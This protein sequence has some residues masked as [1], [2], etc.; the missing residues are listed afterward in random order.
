[1]NQITRIP[2]RLDRQMFSLLDQLFERPGSG[3]GCATPNGNGLIKDLAEA[4]LPLDLS[5]SGDEYLVRASLPGFP[6]ESVTINVEEGVLTIRAEHREQK[7]ESN[8]R[9]IHT[10]RRFTS[11][12]R[13]VELPSKIDASGAK[14][15]LK[16]G[17]LTV[18]LPK[19]ATAFAKTIAI[20]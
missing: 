18:R 1:M 12:S 9:F 11:L 7:D 8:E 17:V 6:K 3:F 5:E 16:D 20:Q 13:R 14:A 15:E 10:E 4:P 19:A 2:S